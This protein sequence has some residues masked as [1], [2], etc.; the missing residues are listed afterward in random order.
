MNLA[1]ATVEA[2]SPR[3]TL[4]IVEDDAAQRLVLNDMLRRMG[5]DCETAATC[6]EGRQL[7]THGR[8]SSSLID[9]GLPDG[10]G[11]SLL[12]EF[13][14]VD[15]NLVSVVLT[16]DAAAETVIDTMRAGAFDYLTKPVDLTTLRAT[17]ARAVAH[18]EVVRERGELVRLLLEERE[19]LRSRVE[20]AT[21]DIRQYARACENTNMR[22]RALLRLTQ[23]TAR[24]YSEEVLFRNAFKELSQ[25]IPLRCVALCDVGRGRLLAAYQ[26]EAEEVEFIHTEGNP[27]HSGYDTLLA[28]AEPK[29]LVQ[30]WVERNAGLD[31]SAFVSYVFPLKFWSRSHC[32]VGFYL[33]PEFAGDEAEQEFLGM[34]AHFLA[35]EW[36]QANLLL[37]VAHHA[38]LGNIA[39]E[40]ARNFVQPLTAIRTAADIVKETVKSPEAGAGMQIIQENVE[41]LKIQTQEFRKLSLRR[42]D[43]VET[44]RLDEYIDQALD[45][46]AVA[47]QNRGVTVVR[48]YE[49]DCE[50]VLLN[51]TALARTFL[52]LIL[53]VLRA[54]QVGTRMAVSLRQVGDGH[55]AFEIRYEGPGTREGAFSTAI[56]GPVSSHPGLQLAE[57]TIH[58]CGGK[59]AVE[60][61]TEGA[62][63]LRVV[64]P[65]NATNPNVVRG[66]TW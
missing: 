8:F 48:D 64:L 57:R 31:T 18:H 39:V 51:G 33:A 17:V 6:A 34:C 5:Y 63:S 35:F 10:N 25:H 21:A 59:L 20:A 29:L 15:P 66:V 3:P 7:F 36:E 54:M 65:R 32:T 4:L 47:I 46:L 38:S 12:Q 37:H 14:A 61:N 41:R 60:Q 27:A 52:D 11:L 58:S 62:Q 24:Y 45:I 9:L 2:P 16:G 26:R 49:G 28:E 50:C 53:C 43:S 1:T 40:L 30:S 13:Q 56:L 19:Q 42:E 44:V 23:L 55:V 22:L